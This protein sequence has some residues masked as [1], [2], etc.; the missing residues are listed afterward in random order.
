M[1]HSLLDRMRRFFD[2]DL[3]DIPEDPANPIQSFFIKSLKI[4]I[5]SGIGFIKDEC[6]ISR[7]V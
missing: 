2:K 3:W 5:S 7:L 4:A 1:K 6:F